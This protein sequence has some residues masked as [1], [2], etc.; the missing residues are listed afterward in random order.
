[1]A[2]PDFGALH[3]ARLVLRLQRELDGLPVD[4]LSGDK[5]VE[6]RTQGIN[7]GIVATSLI[8]AQPGA[9]TVLAMGDDQTDED[10]FAAL[11]DDG[12]AVHIGSRASRAHYRLANTTA[13]RAFLTVS[14]AGELHRVFARRDRT[15]RPSITLMLIFMSANQRI[16]IH[17]VRADKAIDLSLESARHRTSQPEPSFVAAQ[18]QLGRLGKT[19]RLNT[20]STMSS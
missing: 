1:M 15:A 9:V 4:I 19:R 14:C 6:I 13:A 11:P 5:V 18:I 7:K 8:A 12:V 17:S 20:H 3:A 2:D 10:L 16:H